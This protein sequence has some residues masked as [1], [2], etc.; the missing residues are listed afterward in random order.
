MSKYVYQLNK[1]EINNYKQEK[2]I[3]TLGIFSTETNAENAA[4]NDYGLTILFLPTKHKT[5]N[6]ET[7]T[8]RLRSKESKYS[9]MYVIEQFALNSSKYI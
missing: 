5:R 6:Y 3:I 8:K 9:C 7:S 2:S 1:I 4:C